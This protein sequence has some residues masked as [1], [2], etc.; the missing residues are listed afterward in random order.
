MLGKEWI[1]KLFL[2]YIRYTV[3]IKT[4]L[5]ECHYFFLLYFGFVISFAL[6]NFNKTLIEQLHVLKSLKITNYGFKLSSQV[7]AMKPSFIQ[8]ICAPLN[9]ISK[10]SF[11]YI[12]GSKFKFLQ[13]KQRN[14]VFDTILYFLI[15]I[16]LQLK[17][18]NLRFFK[19]RLFNLTEIIVWNIKGLQHQVAK[20]QFL[21][22]R[23]SFKKLKSV[24]FIS[25]KY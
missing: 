18:L 6:N 8:Y 22:G 9:K 12:F 25:I 23:L 2:K 21:C 19:L 20:T 13:V 24:C 15:T 14:W 17:S 4:P 10:T 16:F 11:S 7:L 3:V 5:S 1:N